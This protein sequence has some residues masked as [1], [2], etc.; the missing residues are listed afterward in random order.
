[1]KKLYFNRLIRDKILDKLISKGLKY[2]IKKLNK[3][4]FL[5]ELKAKIPEEAEG[6]VNAKNKKE[7]IEELVDLR[8]V[9]E[10]LKKQHKIT[11]K[12]F[13]SAIKENWL[14]KG[15]FKK[16]IYLDWTSDDGYQTNEK[17]K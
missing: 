15:G 6:V 9:I 5:Q 13:K 17:K 2:K 11:D 8:L 10:E 14:K 7:L 12:E 4:E 3:K 16:R 1:M